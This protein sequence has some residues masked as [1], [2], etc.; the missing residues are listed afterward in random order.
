MTDMAMGQP[1]LLTARQFARSRG[2]FRHAA[3]RIDHDRALGLFVPQQRAVLLERGDRNNQ[4]FRFVQW[5]SR[6]LGEAASPVRIAEMN[7][8]T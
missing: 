7:C 5:N 4:G 6:M 8:W 1:D 3:A 2:R